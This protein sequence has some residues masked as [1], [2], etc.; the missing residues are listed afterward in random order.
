M[1][2]IREAGIDNQI[3]VL[4][5]AAGAL[6]AS[7]GIRPYLPEHFLWDDGL[8]ELTIHGG[9]LVD[10]AESFE[11]VGHLY[12]LAGLGEAPPLAALLGVALYCSGILLAVGWERTARLSM[13]SLLVTMAFFV[14]ALAYLAQ[15]SKELV[16]LG[17]AM[18]V[19]VIPDGR[20]RL[21]T[22][23]GELAVIGGALAYGATLRPYWLI[24]AVMYIGWRI[25]LPRTAHPLLLVALPAAAY[26]VLQP[27]FQ[28]VLGHGLQGAREWS[29]A[30]RAGEQVNT[31][32]QSVAPD[33]RGALGVLAALAM[34]ALMVVPVQLL[35]SGDAFHLASGIAIVVVWALVLVPVL[36]GRFVGARSPRATRA[37]SLLLAFL[38]VQAL[39][40]PDYGS[41]LKHLTPLL[42]LVLMVHL[43]RG[44]S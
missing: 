21:S 34:L 43:H 7:L 30:E 14:P 8:L 13:P 15:Y 26:A 23:M 16:T 9:S 24:I 22:A 37:A 38:V 31:L 18:L 4:L 36:G 28:A 44:R 27:L 17:V 11:R 2:A 29:N 5:A 20:G 39:F 1:R 10:E 12:A 3:L 33:A 6:M 35:V 41:A 19:V 25:L 42:P 32:I 40:E